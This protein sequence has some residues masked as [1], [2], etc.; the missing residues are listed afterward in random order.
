M[1]AGYHALEQLDARRIDPLNVLDDHQDR[2][3]ARGRDEDLD[4]H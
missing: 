2:F 3:P 1:A 4:N